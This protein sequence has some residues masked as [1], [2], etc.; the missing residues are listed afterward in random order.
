MLIARSVHTSK[1]GAGMTRSTSTTI[2]AAGSVLLLGA[3]ALAGC[4]SSGAS[5]SSG[6]PTPPQTASGRPATF[7]VAK[8]SFGSI[9]V[10]SQGRT[11]YLFQRDSGTTSACSGACAVEWPALRVT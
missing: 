3:L 5:N 6:S 7:G 10:D 9:L 8:V 1:E 4:G 2:V 11:L